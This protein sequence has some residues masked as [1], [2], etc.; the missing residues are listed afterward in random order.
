MPTPPLHWHA[1]FAVLE[2]GL[3]Q[4]EAGV[5]I[6]T[7]ATMATEQ[8]LGA[9]IWKQASVVLF[10]AQSLNLVLEP[11]EWCSGLLP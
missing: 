4:F 5:S 1:P 8:A 6:H 3:W 2:M 10:N 11:C 9:G 7:P